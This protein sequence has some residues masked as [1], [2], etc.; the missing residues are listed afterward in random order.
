MMPEITGFAVNGQPKKLKFEINGEIYTLGGRNPVV[1]PLS[2]AK[3]GNYAPPEGIDGYA[4]VNVNIPSDR[5]PEQT[6]TVEVNRNG[7]VVV[8][9]DAGKVL[10]SAT[11]NVRVPSEGTLQLDALIERSITAVRS[12][13]TRIGHSAFTNCSSLTSADFLRATEIHDVVFYNCSSLTTIILRSKTVCTLGTSV[14]FLTPIEQN[15][16]YIYVPK[17]L[18]SQYQAATNW[19]QYASQIRAIEDYPDITGG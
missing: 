16:G 4:P 2:V 17:L 1:E 8:K 13:A 9:P 10:T 5:K 3:N 11:I 14:F 6:K 19:S 12:N 15:A 18:V 7:P